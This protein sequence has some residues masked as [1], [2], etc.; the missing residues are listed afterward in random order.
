MLGTLIFAVTLL[1]ALNRRA[2]L[3]ATLVLLTPLV[4]GFVVA[5]LDSWLYVGVEPYRDFRTFLVTFLPLVLA[6]LAQHLVLRLAVRGNV[7]RT[8]PSA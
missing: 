8:V 2:L 3:G 6:V 7:P 4:A 5:K 1:V